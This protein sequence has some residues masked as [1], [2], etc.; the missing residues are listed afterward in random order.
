MDTKSLAQPAH[1]PNTREHRALAL[2]HE[3]GHK[4]ERIG[5]DLF[6]VPSCTGRA[7]Y[8]VRYGGEGES[9]SCPDFE[10]G[11]GERSC[12]HLLAVGIYHAKHRIRP[13]L[14]AG[15]PFAYAGSRCSCY[16]GVVYI[17]V[18]ACGPETGDEVEVLE[19]VP[20]RRCNR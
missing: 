16:S 1:H 18:M 6:R 5:E 4:I 13:E 11:R 14:V 19:A 9:C 8:T 2:Y 20:C 10:F 3:H 15:D 7:A 17:W 12:K